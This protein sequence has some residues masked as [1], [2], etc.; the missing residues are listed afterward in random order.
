MF[1]LNS[2][3]LRN[4]DDVKIGGI[5]VDQ[6][7]ISYLGYVGA[8]RLRILKL[9]VNFV[10]SDMS[11]GASHTESIKDCLTLVYSYLNFLTKS[12]PNTE[13][14]IV[15]EIM[16]SEEF[17]NWSTE[18]KYRFLNLHKGVIGENTPIAVS[19]ERNSNV[20]KETIDL[21]SYEDTLQVFLDG[22]SAT[23]YLD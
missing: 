3:I 6:K 7:D 22:L 21:V 15:E 18:I 5:N 2:E 10:K 13:E 8:L 17:Q 4:C 20:M 16:N 9:V 11:E 14:G 19:G 12:H 1:F 23:N